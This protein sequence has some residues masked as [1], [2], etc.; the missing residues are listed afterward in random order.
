ML[1]VAM[2][3][4]VKAYY[5]QVLES[6]EK[7]P[8]NSLIQIYINE[9]VNGPIERLVVDINEQNITDI[10]EQIANFLQKAIYEGYELSAVNVGQQPQQQDLLGELSKFHIAESPVAGEQ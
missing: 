6:K 10:T 3:N 2:A 7:F 5:T 1:I 4:N 8:F 9:F